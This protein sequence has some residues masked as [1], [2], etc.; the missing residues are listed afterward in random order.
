[1]SQFRISDL[2]S[3][4]LNPAPGN[5]SRRGA[6][7]EGLVARKVLGISPTPIVILHPEPTVGVALLRML[8]GRAASDD[9]GSMDD[10]C[11]RM[12][13]AQISSEGALTGNAAA[14]NR[15]IHVGTHSPER[16][17]RG[18]GPRTAGVRARTRV[19]AYPACVV[20]QIFDIPGKR[21]RQKRFEGIDH[22]CK[23]VG[24]RGADRAAALAGGGSATRTRRLFAR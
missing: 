1:M 9:F 12:T 22:H 17:G 11:E 24:G 15:D 10:R 18:W 2:R 14:G 3:L 13:L 20:V 5:L 19:L 6:V 8:T 16:S 4:S 7:A 23:L 21:S